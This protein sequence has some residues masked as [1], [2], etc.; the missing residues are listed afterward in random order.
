MQQSKSK[1]T[2][3]IWVMM[4]K[5]VSL[6]FQTVLCSLFPDCPVVV[7]FD[8]GHPCFRS[9]ISTSLLMLLGYGDSF[10]DPTCVPIRISIYKLDLVPNW[11]VAG[12][13]GMFR[14]G[15]GLGMGE[16]YI[17]VMLL[18]RSPCF[19]DSDFAALAG[20]PVNYILFSCV[21]LSVTE[22]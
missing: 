6:F 10:L 12:V 8:R 21:K 17:P 16:S 5:G 3:K 2:A 1:S 20:N 13:V 19:R 18:H 22:L 4:L 9:F 7:F 15:G 14:N 11:I